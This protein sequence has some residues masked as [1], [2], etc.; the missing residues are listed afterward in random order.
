MKI[1]DFLIVFILMDSVTFNAYS[2]VTYVQNFESNES[3]TF[4]VSPWSVKDGDTSLTWGM[5]N[6]NYPHEGERMAFIVFDPSTTTP[7]M[8]EQTIQP[9]GG[10]KFA[11]CLAAMTPPNDDWLISPKIALGTG[12]SLT[13][14][15]KSYTDQYG[16]EKYNAAVSVTDSLP[17]SFQI[18]SGETPKIAPFEAWEQEYFDLS[19]YNGMQV[20]IAIQC[21]SNDAFIFMVDD[22]SVSTTLGIEENPVSK[23]NVYPVPCEGILKID[24]LSVIQ[25]VYVY[26]ASGNLV[27]DQEAGE[28]EVELD[29]SGLTPGLYF[30][31]VLSEGGIFCGKVAVKN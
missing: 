10:V 31:R 4:D 27:I 11:A 29:M 12:S 3:F 21:V 22:I 1:T 13:F 6:V 9:H 30:Y 16:L 28:R 8:T 15:V 7:P 17:A 19:A 24:A 14:W 18:I 23:I 25:R 20:Y 2:Q 5:E 26:D